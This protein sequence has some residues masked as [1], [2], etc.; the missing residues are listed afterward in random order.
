[1]AVLLRILLLLLLLEE[2]IEFVIPLATRIADPLPNHG[3]EAVN[4]QALLAIVLL[5]LASLSPG[6]AIRLP[7]AQRLGHWLENHAVGR[8][9]HYQTMK[10][11]GSRLLG[12]DGEWEGFRPVLLRSDAGEC[13]PAFFME[14]PDREWVAIMLSWSPTPMA[15]NI[16][17]VPA[18]RARLLVL[19]LADFTDLISRLGMGA[20]ALLADGRDHSAFTAKD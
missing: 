13:E 19:S 5:V 14:K 20:K 11:F 7:A 18:H 16:R 8:L 4:A 10:G 1:M 17:I 6:L 9:P 2:I 3:L 12:P 15:G